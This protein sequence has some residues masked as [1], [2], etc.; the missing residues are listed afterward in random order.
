MSLTPG[1]ILPLLNPYF[2]FPGACGIWGD[3]G[4]ALSPQPC[5]V[6]SVNNPF[7]VFELV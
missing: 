3:T 2:S 6:A 5:R 7:G 4:I 1:E